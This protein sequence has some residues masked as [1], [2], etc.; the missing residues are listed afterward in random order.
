MLASPQQGFLAGLRHPPPSPRSLVHDHVHERQRQPRLQHGR[1][2]PARSLPDDGVGRNHGALVH[3]GCRQG[4]SRGQGIMVGREGL[5]FGRVGNAAAF[6]HFPT[7]RGLSGTDQSLSFH[8]PV[9]PACR[10]DI[11]LALADAPE[12]RKRG[13]HLRGSTAG[14][15]RRGRDYFPSSFFGS[16]GAGTPSLMDSRIAPVMSVASLV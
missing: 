7:G 3:H 12:R 8:P 5:A 4:P 10:M 6:P 1:E 14:P 15:G 16:A 9:G 13:A 2:D 11:P